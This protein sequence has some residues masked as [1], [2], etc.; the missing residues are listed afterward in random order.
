MRAGCIQK[1]LLQQRGWN[2]GTK[3]DNVVKG[4]QEK[5]LEGFKC[6]AEKLDFFFFSRCRNAM[7]EEC[8]EGSWFRKDTQFRSVW[9]I[10]WRGEK[11]SKEKP[12]G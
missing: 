12:T 3:E 1:Q 4:S 11:E 8:H 5:I 9:R 10:Y 2:T 7:K 6:S